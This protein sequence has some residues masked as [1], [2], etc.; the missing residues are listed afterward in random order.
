M[1]GLDGAKDLFGA[2]MAVRA[3]LEF[4]RE[5]IEQDLGIGCRTEMT[6]IF[7]NEVLGQFVVIGQVAVMREAN[8][9]GRIDV[10]GLRFRRLGAAGRRIANVANANVALEP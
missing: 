7:A 5:D 9:V 1:H 2:W 6:A 4:V 3:F 10:E 8:A